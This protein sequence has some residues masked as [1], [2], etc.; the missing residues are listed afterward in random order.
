MR[1]KSGEIHLNVELFSS[2]V[3]PLGTIIFL[4]GFTGSS[5]DWV[6]SA[7]KIDDRFQKAGIDLIGHGESDSPD[8][9]FKYSLT[10]VIEHIK[11]VID[12]FRWKN[13]FLLGYSMGG[14]IALTYANKFQHK[15][16]GLILESATAGIEDPNERIDRIKRDKE[17]SDFILFH[18]LEEFTDY[19][20]DL[21][22][23][24]TQKRFS[25][26]RLTEIKKAKLK[27][28]KTGLANSLLGYGTGAMPPLFDR[29][30]FIKIPTLL[31]SGEL[32]TKFTSV[33][34]KLVRHLPNAEHVIIKNAGHNTHL[35]ESEKF[36]E[37]V[38][39]FLKKSIK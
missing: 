17:L 11:D 29:L 25:N 22:I 24:Q 13:I 5:E 33:N 37:V 7:N 18:S 30:P 2:P 31:I 28:N 4:H 39:G 9:Q 32:D 12:Y 14:R 34:K 1:I 16:S 26:P 8:E 20:M 15:I 3:N 27:N 38:N 10:N 19:W 35:E 36:V 21:E 23:F 6:Y